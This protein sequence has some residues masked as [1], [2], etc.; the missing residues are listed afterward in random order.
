MSKLL[1]R[2]IEVLGQ[3]TAT[4]APDGSNAGLQMKDFLGILQTAISKYLQSLPQPQFHA[5][6]SANGER[7]LIIKLGDNLESEFQINVVRK[8]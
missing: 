6:I 4:P 8:S 5:Q 2:A 7:G 3:T 1:V